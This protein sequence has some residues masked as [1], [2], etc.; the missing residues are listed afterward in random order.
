MLVTSLPEHLT[1]SCF[2]LLLQYNLSGRHSLTVIYTH[3]T[4]QN[5]QRSHREMQ[6]CDQMIV[7][8]GLNF[9]CLCS[10]W[11]KM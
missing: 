2:N 1:F 7:G 3:K 4:V 5:H 8:K 11:R 10:A 6:A 9:S